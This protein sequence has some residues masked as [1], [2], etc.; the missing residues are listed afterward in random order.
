MGSGVPGLYFARAALEPAP[1]PLRTD[2]AG[3]I[4]R[5]R[6]GPVGTKVR[7]E[8]WREYMRV[9]GG[10]AS[11]ALTTYAIRGYFEN[12][13]QVAHV[14]RVADPGVKT[15][16]AQW[17]VKQPAAGA[18]ALAELP[19]PFRYNSYSVEADSP[20]G[21]ANGARVFIR[22][23]RSGATGK[24]ELDIAVAVPEE[25]TAYSVG[26][27]LGDLEPH[28]LATG[29][30]QAGLVLIAPE[31]PAVTTLRASGPQVLSWGLALSGGT[32]GTGP[33]LQG[34]TNA[35]ALLSEEEEVALMCVPD[36]HCDLDDADA[37]AEFIRALVAEAEDSK[38]RLV[39]LDL[40]DDP[41]E[42]QD[43]VKGA[44]QALG[45]V[46]GLP[47]SDVPGGFRAAAAYHPRLWVPDPFGGI[48]NPLKRIPPAGH[49]AGLI[50][51]LDRERGAHHTPANAGLLEAIDITQRFKP[52]QQARFNDAGINLLRC[53]PGR[54]LQVWGGRTLSQEPATRFIAHRRLMHRLVRAIRRVTAP[55]VFDTNGPE[56]WLAI[57]RAVTTVLLEAYRKGALKGARPDEAF[58][59]R[60]DETTT[61]VD[62]R[63]LGRVFCEIEF[64]PAVPMEFIL[65][66]IALSGE[67][68]LEVF[69]S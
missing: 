51:R 53:M 8:G 7:V 3:F 50:S 64:A 49:V 41:D 17:N 16:R 35:L 30:V 44:E 32:D 23:R 31:D 62:E 67:G 6:R 43:A 27:P 25:P 65:L 40:P 38:D 59:V 45:W 57:V 29:G 68:T 5:T 52:E 9:F 42:P 48:T 19:G 36:L 24:A 56:L 46:A 21:W 47:R 4:G 61:P 33:T 10:I 20:G 58:R 15:A 14:V 54:G 39:L 60:C 22:Y 12:G 69:E 66:R 13:G 11:D 1:S 63:E 55:L 18:Q 37:K 28:D 2:V 26:L 34:Y